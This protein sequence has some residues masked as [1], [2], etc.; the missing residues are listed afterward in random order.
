M[1]VYLEEGEIW[2]LK[3]TSGIYAHKTIWELSKKLAICKPRGEFSE[4]T[5]PANIMLLNF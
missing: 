5:K 3:E 4:K 1:N 2:I